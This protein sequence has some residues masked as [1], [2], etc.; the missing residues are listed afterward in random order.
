MGHNAN[1]F[2]QAALALGSCRAALR[3]KGAAYGGEV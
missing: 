2:L 1:L 3:R